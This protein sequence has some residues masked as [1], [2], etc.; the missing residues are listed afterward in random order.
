[1][2]KIKHCNSFQLFT[3]QHMSNYIFTYQEKPFYLENGDSLSNIT[4]AYTTYGTYIP[5]KSKVVWV[6]HALTANADVFDWWKGLFGENDL[7]NPNEYFIVCANILGS[8]YGT[9]NAL[10]INPHT[11]TPYYHD[12]PFIT[13]RD[14]V[15]AHILLRKHL[16]IDT[17]SY[18]IGGSLGG[19]QA[20]EWAIMEKDIV[21]QLILIATNAI[22]SPWGIAFNE[23]QRM[24]IET[25]STWIEQQQNAGLQG[26][27]AARVVALLSYRNEET[28]FHFQQESEQK[29]KD[30]RAASYQ[31]YQGEKLCQRF[32]AFSYYTLSKSMDS[33]NICR[34]RNGDIETVLQDISAKTLLIGISSD[35]LFPVKEQKLIA[36]H[37]AHAHYFEIDSMYG[38][39]GFLIETDKISEAIALFF[40]LNDKM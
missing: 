32:N 6:C 37:I 2:I 40:N 16:G 3:Y 20:L 31:R 15:Q 27:K 4:I 12:F 29:T 13:I 9:T 8:C 33:H 19:Q 23:S 10:S 30:F 22:H 18:L 35:I 39:D 34:D 25:D 11:N 36:K 14:M 26:M 21:Q 38:H 1:M 5:T 24:C 17:I 28:Y 7:F